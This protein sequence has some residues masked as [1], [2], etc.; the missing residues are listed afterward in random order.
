MLPSCRGT[1]SFMVG[2]QAYFHH[3]TYGQ[4][5]SLPDAVRAVKRWHS[6]STP[7]VNASLAPT[8]ATVKQDNAK[9][10]YQSAS[11]DWPTAKAFLK[12]VAY[13]LCAVF[14]LFSSL[15]IYYLV[16]MQQSLA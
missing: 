16:T 7:V 1:D 2:I 13:I 5:R 3:P 15:V 12:A 6:S 14:V 10:E 4:A 9:L 8:V 11:F